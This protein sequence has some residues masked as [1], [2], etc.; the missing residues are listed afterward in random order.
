MYKTIILL[1]LA[2]KYKTDKI[3]ALHTTIK[4]DN[5][6]SIKSYIQW[7]LM[8]CSR[9]F[10]LGLWYLMPLSTIFQ[11]YRQLALMVEE[12]GVPRENHRPVTCH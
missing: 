8:V 11:L 7:K 3:I 5:N 9:K 12:T 1:L 10:G 2:H 4:H 6:N